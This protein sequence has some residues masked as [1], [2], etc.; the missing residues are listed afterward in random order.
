M[1][2]YVHSV[3]TAI[4]TFVLA[5]EQEDE[6]KDKDKHPHP[7]ATQSSSV[8]TTPPKV[9][10]KVRMCD[11]CNV[12]QDQNTTALKTCARCGLAHY[13]G[14]TCQIAHWKAGHKQVCGVTPL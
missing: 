2:K 11:N 13:C 8:T 5:N 1:P 7:H 4:R 12:P 14:K 9:K 10:I 6:D 3:I